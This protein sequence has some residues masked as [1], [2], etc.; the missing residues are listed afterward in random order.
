MSHYMG[1]MAL[2]VRP[3]TKAEHA[4]L[5]KARRSSNGTTSRRAIVL[6]LSEAGSKVPEIAQTV[7]LSQGWVRKLI[8][9]A[10][11]EGI[12]SVLRPPRKC[13]GRPRRFGEQVAVALEGLLNEP[14]SRHGFETTRWTLSD[15]AQAAQI[16][17][18]VDSID[19]ATVWR[20]LLSRGKS[21]KQA[22]RRMTSPDPEYQEKRG[23]ARR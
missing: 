15:L 14:P 7:G 20:L 13:M 21:W 12:A 1:A 6:A 8:H 2:Y 22:K 10:N 3:L 19:P 5:V 23:C 16:T 4:A 11:R 17:G 18:L 9:T